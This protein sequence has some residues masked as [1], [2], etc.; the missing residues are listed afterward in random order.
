MG[1]LPQSSTL[2]HWSRH[3]STIVCVAFEWQ[4]DR[5]LW[6]VAGGFCVCVYTGAHEQP[7]TSKQLAERWAKGGVQYLSRPRLSTGRAMQL[8][9]NDGELS[10][11]LFF[12]HT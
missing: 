5:D 12:S 3:K 8:L 2:V 6:P 1:S 4:G 11:Q 10:L 9:D 7:T